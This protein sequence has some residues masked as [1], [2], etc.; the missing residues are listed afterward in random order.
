[1]SEAPDWTVWLLAIGVVA[2]FVWFFW[3]TGAAMLNALKVLIHLIETAPERRRAYAEAE[4]RAGGR[5]P[6]WYRAGRVLAL[7]ALFALVAYIVW[8]KLIR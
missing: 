2:L 6:L 8:V 7:T 3:H 1:M 4:A 5:F